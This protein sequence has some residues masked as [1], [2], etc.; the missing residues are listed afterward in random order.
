[1]SNEE[2][3][4]L[5]SKESDGSYISPEEKPN[6][7]GGSS[8]RASMH[9]LLESFSTTERQ[10]ALKELGVGPAASMIKDAVLGYQDAPY[11]GFYDPYANPD[12]VVR[13]MVSIVCGRFI[14]YYWIK[15]LLLAANW[16][17]FIL[18]FLE[19][20]HWCRDSDLVI[21]K[22]NLNDD[23]SEYGDCQLI[24]GAIGTAADGDENQD[25][26]PSSNSMLLS[27]SQSKRVE[28]ICIFAI[29][30]FN[31][32]KM[33]DDGFSPRLYFYPGFK[34]WMHGSQ[35][36]IL[37]CLFAG[38][39]VG[40]TIFNP[41]FRMMILGT[42]LRNF[43]REFWIMLKMIPKMGYIL[44]ILA[45]VVIF[46]AWFGVVIF[47]GTE[48]GASGF[49]N[50]IEAIWTLWICITTANYPDVM[51]P[52][53][54]ENR[55]AALYFV[56][57][58]TISFFY[59]MNLVLAVTVNL[60]DDSIA[61]RKRNRKDLSRNLLEKAYAM[62]DPENNDAV[63]RET[64]MAVMFIL[65]QDVPEIRRLSR[66]EKGIVFAFL[67]KDGS[68]DISLVEFLDFS[69]I[70]LLK[71]TKESDYKSFVER[72]LPQVNETNWYQ[73]L[74]KFI[75][76]KT[77]E[78]FIDA[79]LVLNAVVVAFQDYPILS[80]Q[81]VVGNPHFEDGH[82]DT[83]WELMETIFTVVYVLEAALKI[84]I[85][86]WKRYT[87]SMRNLFD[88]GVTV[89][90]LLVTVYVY[91]SNGYSSTRIIQLV[92]MVRVLRLGR[93]FFVSQAPFQMFGTITLDILPAA[94]SV[95]MILLFIGYFYAWV[96]M[97]LYGGSYFF[98]FAFSK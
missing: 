51:M 87:E 73:G 81:D 19:P 82:V 58:M 80:G 64:I 30:F 92:I 52:S 68:S 65:N 32:L 27:V 26:Y 79:V 53:Y 63:S 23:L 18:S 75:R 96:G 12:S 70:L 6:S 11:E 74:V 9:R 48:Q 59:L 31:F 16:A 24:L 28:L 34:R 37:V 61:E 41:F 85:E 4:P 95:F 8:F 43:Q 66:D 72:H 40:N 1:M 67:D 89:L 14:A 88:F 47:H 86:G 69:K 57:F 93:L 60:Y 35:F 98:L 25:Y 49:Q 50:L 56:S 77:F 54:N 45:I 13:N 17:L 15:R 38:N 83:V 94:T 76:S 46:Y 21:A 22:G 5:V 78:Y 71:L 91:Y 10:H 36:V 42:H 7:L 62:L 39:V 29:A 97:S 55:V 2:K 84:L 44:T 33:G 90:V 20:P 3:V